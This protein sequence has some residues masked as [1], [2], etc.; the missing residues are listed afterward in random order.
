M[1][2]Y[3]IKPRFVKVKSSVNKIHNINLD[4]LKKLCN[5]FLT[6]LISI[7][8]LHSWWHHIIRHGLISSLRREDQRRLGHVLGP[9]AT[10]S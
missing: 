10:Q 2:R 5:K 3:N 9:C 7:S 8:H 4:R 1:M 6:I